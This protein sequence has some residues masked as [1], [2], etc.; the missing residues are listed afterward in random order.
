MS[1]Q[2]PAFRLTVARRMEPKAL[3]ERVGRRIRAARL[4][5][6]LE[7]R[8]LA[9]ELKI[10]ERTLERWELGE[11]Y[12][13]LRNRNAL[14]ERLQALSLDDLQPDL[15]AEERELRDQLDRIE[16]M[17]ASVVDALGIEEGA[18]VHPLEQINQIAAALP[19]LLAADDE[20]A[21]ATETRPAGS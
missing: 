20:T 10:A 2:I 4:R 14:V 1:S 12:P 18:D 13:Q 19:G 3:R 9:Y 21:A 11:V 7:P 8:D 6:G 17:L 16:N 5:E 15:E